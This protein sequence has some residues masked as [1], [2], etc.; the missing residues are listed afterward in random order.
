MLTQLT[1]KDKEKADINSKA[2]LLINYKS[3]MRVI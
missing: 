3:S 1:K 2:A